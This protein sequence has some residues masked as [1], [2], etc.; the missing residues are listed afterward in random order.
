MARR[1]CRSRKVLTLAV[2]IVL[3]ALD[4][5]AQSP[6]R[7]ASGVHVAAPLTGPDNSCDISQSS[8]TWSTIGTWLAD[9]DQAGVEGN[10]WVMCLTAAAIS[11]GS[12]ITWSPPAW[13]MLKC[14]GSLTTQGGGD[15][16]T[17][18]D[19]FNSGNPILTLNLS[20]TGVFR[21]A[22]CTFKGSSGVA[23]TPKSDG[24]ISLNGPNSL[25]RLDHLHFDPRDYTP[26]G[27]YVS[28]SF[29]VH[30]RVYGLFDHSILRSDNGDG[31]YFTNG[32]GDNGNGDLIWSQDTGMGGA[33]FF[34]MEDNQF[35]GVDETS[36]RVGDSFS[37]SRT[38]L[39]FN[40]LTNAGGLEQHHTGQQAGPHGPRAHE[41]YGNAFLLSGSLPSIVGADIG[42]GSWVVWG[43]AY[44]T[45]QLKE[46]MRFRVNRSEGTSGCLNPVCGPVDQTA[47]PNGWGYCG[48]EHSGTGSNWDGGTF[49]STNTTKGYPCLDQPS[50]GKHGQRMS[51]NF[52]S[53]QNE[54]T[55][56]VAWPQQQKEEIYIWKNTGTPHLGYGG[57]FL[58]DDTFGRM[59]VNTDYFRQTDGS[60]AEQSSSSVPFNGDGTPGV[61]WGPIGFRPECASGCVLGS[62]YWAT[63]QGSWNRSSTNPYG[64]QQN[65]ASGKFYV[66]TADGVWTARYGG[67]PSNTSG[68]PYQYP[69]PLN[70]N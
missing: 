63:D 46:L 57:Q 41:Q 36:N 56:S 27:N 47:T 60:Q 53:K 16:T 13:V 7:A 44:G 65:G 34:F 3:L 6:P 20:A 58:N 59:T 8:T 52:P 14:N 28:I 21:L 24:L 4:V 9:N 64:A 37:A 31:P 48:N 23:G 67:D 10:P 35:I 19:T 17:I 51:G 32:A 2:A 38:V 70:V 1:P 30:D 25:V 50:R 43:N 12:Q 45:Q 26:G 18:T 11:A 33:N 42:N 66:L 40:T 49:N 55:M 29:F 69:H 54:T 61:G 39:R 68:E 5:W 62:G 15:A 22:A